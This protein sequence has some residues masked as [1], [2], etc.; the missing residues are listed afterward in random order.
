VVAAHDAAVD[1]AIGYLQRAAGF[2]RR[3]AGGAETLKVDG[4]V[5]AAFRHR[6]SRADDPLL[7]THVLVA[8]LARTSDD[9]IWRTLDSRKLF[10]H[11]KTA[12]V[13][14]QAQLRHEL[15][16]RLGVAWQPVVNGVADIAGADRQLIDT[17]SQRR[18][19]I[20]HHMAARGETSA[21]AAQTATLATRQAKSG[22]PSE[23]ELREGWGRRA[24]AAGVTPGWHHQLLGRA[25]WGRPDLAQLWN[26]LVVEEGLTESSSTFGRREVLQ[27]LADRLPAGA[28][29][30]WV[31]QAAD[32]ILTHD[33]D[34]L[35]TLGPTRGQLSAVDV[36]RRG[37]G[38]IVAADI[39]HADPA[40]TMQVYAHALDGDDATAAETPPPPSSATDEHPPTP[41]PTSGNA[42]SRPLL[43][44]RWCHRRRNA[45]DTGQGALRRFRGFRPRR[46]A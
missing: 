22:H 24:A 7:H 38:R 29:V 26:D 23:A 32:A 31:E 14:Y 27:H 44:S 13:L 35:V 45:P 3:G 17:F 28:P 12:G 41:R 19:A 36:I 5:A 16:R 20:V 1:A 15:T 34:L 21:A 40:V 43:V 8:N 42:V 37:D 4:F 6:T 46:Q 33:T 9:G 11:A 25:S 30:A 18:T 39:G 10:A 2:S